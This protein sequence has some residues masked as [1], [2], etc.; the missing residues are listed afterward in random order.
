MDFCPT[1]FS[2]KARDH[3]E[4]EKVHSYRELLPGSVYQGTQEDEERVI[5]CIMRLFLVFAL[6]ACE[7]IEQQIWTLD[8]F[9]RE[10]EEFLRRVTIMVIHDRAPGLSNR[11]ISNWNGLVLPEVKRRFTEAPEWKECEQIKLRTLAIDQALEWGRKRILG[12][13][14]ENADRKKNPS[15]HIA[16]YDIETIEYQVRRRLLED[17]KL[18]RSVE[19]QWQSVLFNQEMPHQ[20]AVL[21]LTAV[22]AS[23][24]AKVIS[25]AAEQVADS[26][27]TMAISRK[28]E[29]TNDFREALWKQCL[30]FAY[31]LSHWNTF[32]AWV[33]RAT[34][35]MWKVPQTEEGTIDRKKLEVTV[36]QRRQFYE[37]RSGWSWR[38]WLIAIDQAVGLRLTL[39]AVHNPSSSRQKNS[40]RPPE[41][42]SVPTKWQELQVRGSISQKEAAQ[43][44]QCDP[45]TIR[46]LT[47]RHEL[48]KSDKGRIVCDPQLRNQIRKKHGLQVVR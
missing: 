12:I 45:R 2:R 46:R 1:E 27:V 18:P 43:L 20:D 33:D 11:W 34:P 39:S 13:S 24:Y 47:A 5:K 29:I 19:A 16:Q 32:A 38:E 31:Q 26:L 37:E 6:E 17:A 25:K 4:Y 14:A 30:K 9:D 7:L 15:L 42:V 48:T 40:R 21:E 35:V 41:P 44:L 23:E 8:R 22:L 10:A 3:L 28:L 36:A